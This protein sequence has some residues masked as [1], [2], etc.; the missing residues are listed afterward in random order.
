MSLLEGKHSIK[1]DDYTQKKEKDGVGHFR[2]K[3]Y[4]I[5]MS[6]NRNHKGNLLSFADRGDEWTT[7]IGRLMK[8]FQRTSI[9]A[10]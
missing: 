6:Q 3:F 4:R 9:I 10:A 5:A 1:R 8:R 2:G 7:W